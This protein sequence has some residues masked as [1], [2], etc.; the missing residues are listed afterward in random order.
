MAQGSTIAGV[1]ILIDN[2][3]DDIY[4]AHRRVQGH[5]LG[6]I[7]VVIDRSGDDSYRCVMWGQGIGAPLGFGLLDDV[8]G[9]DYYFAGGVYRDS[10][11][12]TPGLEGWGQ[13]VGAGIRQVA[14]GGVGVLLEGGGDDTYEFDYLAHG[15]GYWCALGFLRDFGGNDKHLGSTEKS[16]NGGQRTEPEY[17]RFGNGW[18]C[19]YAMGFLFEDGGNDVYRGAIMGLGFGWD[20]SLG[21]LC[22]FG[23]NDRYDASGGTV[24]GNGAQASTG[25]LFDYDGDD[26]Y[27]GYG[28]GYAQSGISYHPLPYCGG[29]FSFVV[30]YGGK[31]EY[32][33]EADNNSITQRGW[34]GGFIV[35]RPSTAEAATIAAEARAAEET[36]RKS[37]SD[38]DSR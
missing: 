34:A 1:G 12:E 19:H 22:D 4:Q 21:C 30:D 11:P 20:C 17:Q 15:G 26:V 23:G 6:G 35:D 9:S 3:G 38:T 29:N 28:Q 10:Y 13:G 33:C 25:I 18:G 8:S 37:D 5:A 27:V 24:E 14:N 31:D 32:G 2:A 7:G 16:F 36:A